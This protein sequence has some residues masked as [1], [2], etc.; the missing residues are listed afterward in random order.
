MSGFVDRASAVALCEQIQAR[1][2][3]CFVRATA[4]DA[5]LQWVKAEGKTQTA[6]ATAPK[7]AVPAA[8]QGAV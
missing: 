7:A 5:P 3:A 4:G 2:G 6:H 1:K 8:N